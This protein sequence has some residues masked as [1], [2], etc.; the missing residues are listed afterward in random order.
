MTMMMF[1]QKIK[2]LHLSSPLPL[3][4]IHT[5]KCF[6]LVSKFSCQQLKRGRDKK[7]WKSQLGSKSC[8][9]YCEEEEERSKQQFVKQMLLITSSL[10]RPIKASWLCMKARPT[11]QYRCLHACTMYYHVHNCGSLSQEHVLHAY[12]THTHTRMQYRYIHAGI[13]GSIE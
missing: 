3:S 13:T 6:F 7:R 1:E 5:W 8:Y 2:L 11:P 12:S 9:Y 10:A 4:L